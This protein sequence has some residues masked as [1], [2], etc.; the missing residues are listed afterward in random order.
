MDVLAHVRPV[1]PKSLGVGVTAGQELEGHPAQADLWL[2][3]EALTPRREFIQLGEDE[4]GFPV[5]ANN[6]QDQCV[7]L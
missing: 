7:C 3:E 1:E 2:L 5:G 4:A 6:A